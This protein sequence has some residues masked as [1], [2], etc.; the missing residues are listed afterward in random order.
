MGALDCSMRAGWALCWDISRHSFHYRLS[1]R[2][3]ETI[4]AELRCGSTRFIWMM[5]TSPGMD[6]SPC[7]RL[8]GISVVVKASKVL[9]KINFVSQSQRLVVYLRICL[10]FIYEQL[11]RKWKNLCWR[12]QRVAGLESTKREGVYTFTSPSVI[13]FNQRPLMCWEYCLRNAFPYPPWYK[14]PDNLPYERQ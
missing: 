5:E 6:R 12:F 11:N 10:S 14:G 9:W 13:Y 2:W 3:A 7:E 8:C 1:S 4:K